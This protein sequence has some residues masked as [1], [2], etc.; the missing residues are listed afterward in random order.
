MIST[1]VPDHLLL[2]MFKTRCVIFRFVF[3][4]LGAQHVDGAALARPGDP[5]GPTGT[6][7]PR[8]HTPDRPYRPSSPSPVSAASCQFDTWVSIKLEIIRDDVIGVDYAP[9]K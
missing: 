4:E 7:G 6:S 8:S 9:T 5:A 3:S 2:D 1:H